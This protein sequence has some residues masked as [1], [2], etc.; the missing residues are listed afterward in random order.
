VH[1]RRLVELGL[2]GGSTPE[3]TPSTPQHSSA[4]VRSRHSPPV[5]AKVFERVLHVRH[6]A[7]RG[8]NGS[9]AHAAKLDSLLVAHNQLRSGP[10]RGF[11]VAF[12]VFHSKSYFYGGF[13]LSRRVFDSA[14]W[15]VS[16]RVDQRRLSTAKPAP[17]RPDRRASRGQARTSKGQRNPRAAFLRPSWRCWPTRPSAGRAR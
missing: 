2:L 14:V 15:G 12:A 4:I 11:Y 3:S 7:G 10:R 1:G 17:L 6:S 8:T 9:G 13:L 16:A 5:A